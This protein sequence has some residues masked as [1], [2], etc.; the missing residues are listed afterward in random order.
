MEWTSNSIFRRYRISIRKK[1]QGIGVLL[2]LEAKNLMQV[3]SAWR[4][5][6]GENFNLAETI[7]YIFQKWGSETEAAPSFLKQCNYIHTFIGRSV[8]F[9]V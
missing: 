4:M 3:Y 5:N 6:Y 7:V 9:N 1:I 2:K 8:I